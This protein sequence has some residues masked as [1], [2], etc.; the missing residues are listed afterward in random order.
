MISALICYLVKD[1][2]NIF[3]LSRLYQGAMIGLAGSLVRSFTT[4]WAEKY[5]DSFFYQLLEARLV[6]LKARRTKK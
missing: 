6:I 2:Y 3:G 1:V 4:N 5:V